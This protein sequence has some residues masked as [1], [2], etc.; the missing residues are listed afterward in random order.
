MG[1]W[2]PNARGRLEKAALELYDERGFD[3][4]TV[5]EIAARAGLTER[6]FFRHFADK[7]EVLFGGSAALGEHLA[8]GTLDAPARL[9][10]VEAIAH[11][12]TEMAEGVFVGER[13][14]LARRRAA[15]IAAHPDLRERELVKMASYSAALAKAVRQ[16]G[17]PEPLAALAAEA[18]IAIFKVSFERWLGAADPDPAPAPAAE[19]R[20]LAEFIDE[21]MKDLKTITS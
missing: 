13:L 19:P 21:A 8:Q 4:T 6:T 15:I 5:A 9:G 20:P 2:E 1:R 16:R 17:V 7:R 12:L 10:P 14:P 3:A 18:G 11:S